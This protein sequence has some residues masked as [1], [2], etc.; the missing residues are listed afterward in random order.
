[1]F[2]RKKIRNIIAYNLKLHQM[3]L[4]TIFGEDTH[5]AFGE[6]DY[7]ERDQYFGND[8]VVVNVVR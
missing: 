4:L 3:K 7:N 8:F 5:C 6:R 2:L 1:M